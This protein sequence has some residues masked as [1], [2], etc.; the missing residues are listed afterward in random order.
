[1]ISLHLLCIQVHFP[2]FFC[3]FFFFFIF[4]QILLGLSLL[5]VEQ[6]EIVV[7]F[8]PSMMA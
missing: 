5:V 6:V 1:M 3:L 7:A 4:L 8:S 2:E